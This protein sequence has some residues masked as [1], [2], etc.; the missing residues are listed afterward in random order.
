MPFAKPLQEKNNLKNIIADSNNNSAHIFVTD[1]SFL[2]PY[3]VPSCNRE[4]L[5]DPT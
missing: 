5:I 3:A 4:D 1:K 2:T